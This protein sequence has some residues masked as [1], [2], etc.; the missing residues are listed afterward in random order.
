MG[1]GGVNLPPAAFQK[2]M[3]PRSVEYRDSLRSI[4][5]KK[6]CASR[7]RLFY[8]AVELS[9]VIVTLNNAEL[10]VLDYNVH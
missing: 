8:N 9:M 5:S 7:T 2:A 6:N 4:I 10:V 3:Y 1:W